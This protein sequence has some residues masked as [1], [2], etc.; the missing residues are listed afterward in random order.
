MGLVRSMLKEKHLPL[1]LWGEAVST[2]VYVLNRSSTKGVKGHTPY[3]KWNGRKPNVS[4]LK[5]FGS[6]VFVK[7]TRRLSKLEDR[8]KCMVFTGYE[9]GSKA[10]RCL[11]PTTL[12]LLI[13][14]DL[15]FDETESFEFSEQDK[16]RKFSSCPSNILHVTGLEEGKR[17]PAEG[18]REDSMIN[19]SRERELSQSE[20][21]E[22]EEIVR[23][24]SI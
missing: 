20:D 19:E 13:S 14:R 9:V 7:T 2:C 8:S 10:Y 22:E 24:R 4:H 5:I 16:L 11:D 1:E 3:E 12:R 18:P 15:I 21:S 6:V 23:Y 17:E